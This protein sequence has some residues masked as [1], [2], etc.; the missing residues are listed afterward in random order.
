MT[1][2]EIQKLDNYPITWY[3]NVLRLSRYG[4]RTLCL[5]ICGYANSVYDAVV[6]G[7]KHSSINAL[8]VF[9]VLDVYVTEVGCENAKTCMNVDCEW[10][11]ASR[12]YLKR[13]NCTVDEIREMHKRLNAAAQLFELKCKA[14][15]ATI[16]YEKPLGCFIKK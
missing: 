2:K 14:E 6:L 11:K 4:K 13:F 7:S 16:V 9:V 15:G 12:S 8:K 3:V 5:G 1:A 10:N